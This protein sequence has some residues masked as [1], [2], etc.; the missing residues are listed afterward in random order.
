MTSY[1]NRLMTVAL[2][3]PERFRCAISNQVPENPKASTQCKHVFEQ[4]VV[5]HYL[6]AHHLCPKDKC[7]KKIVPISVPKKFVEEF[8]QHI[9]A[10]RIKRL[11]SHIGTGLVHGVVQGTLSMAIVRSG[12]VDEKKNHCGWISTNAYI[13]SMPLLLASMGLVL[14][15]LVKNNTAL[16]INACMIG[17]L[18]STSWLS[19]TLSDYALNGMCSGVEFMPSSL[20]LSLLLIGGYSFLSQKF[21]LRHSEIK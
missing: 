7:R 20:I 5:D 18:G 14:A 15:G 13:C 4:S 9:F 17:V 1:I 11:A 3:I 19:G 12:D 16:K 2:D 6:E 10:Q 8:R 21:S